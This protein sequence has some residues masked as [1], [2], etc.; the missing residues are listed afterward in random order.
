MEAILKDPAVGIH[1]PLQLNVEE[2]KHQNKL[3]KLAFSITNIGLTCPAKFRFLN[4]PTPTLQAKQ[5]YPCPDAQKKYATL[6][7]LS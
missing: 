1:Q 3:S 2:V 7:A 5:D 6:H 4:T